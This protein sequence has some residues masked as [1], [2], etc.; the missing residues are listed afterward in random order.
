MTTAVK[1]VAGALCLQR[2]TPLASGSPHAE[3][4]PLARF[5]LQTQAALMGFLHETRQANSEVHV[6]EDTRIAKKMPRG[7]R[8]ITPHWAPQPLVA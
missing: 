3:R 8:K 1:G 7:N 5:T 6:G 2:R 4:G